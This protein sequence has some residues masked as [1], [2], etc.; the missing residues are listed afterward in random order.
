[1]RPQLVIFDVDGTLLDTEARWKE[2]WEIIGNKYNAPELGVDLFY[3]LI[4]KSG[5]EELLF[6][7]SSECS[8][9]LA[10][11]VGKLIY[12]SYDDKM[13]LSLH[14]FV[15]VIIKRHNCF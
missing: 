2:A 4:G 12:I 7:E 15:Y 13:Y 5:K 6:I 9:V 10:Q 11:T 1:M 3:K 14:F 8:D